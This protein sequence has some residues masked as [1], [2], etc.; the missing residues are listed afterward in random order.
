MTFSRQ[1]FAKNIYNLI[2]LLYVTLCSAY[3]TTITKFSPF[4]FGLFASFLLFF[5]SFFRISSIK[6]NKNK[7]VLLTFIILIALFSILNIFITNTYSYSFGIFFLL[8]LN[9]FSTLYI[10]STLK[11][12]NKIS[13]IR[14]SIHIYYWIA[15]IIGVCD[16]IYRYLTRL[17]SYHGLQYIYNF[18]MSSLMF[19]DA[20]WV[21]FIYMIAFSFFLY[22]YDIY[23]LV[24]K[25][26]L[27]VLF[28][29]VL[30]SISR[31]AFF[32]SIIVLIYSKFLKSPKKQKKLFLILLAIFSFVG[33][34]FVVDY[35]LHDDSFQTKLIILKGFS[36]YL[37][38][39]SIQ[40]LF[41]GFGFQFATS[42]RAE[43][44]MNYCGVIGHLYIVTKMMDFGMI[45]FA[46]EIIYFIVLLKLTQYR[47][48]YLLLPFLV[49]GLSMCPTNLSFFYTFAGI[50]LFL[51][52]RKRSFSYDRF[53]QRY[54][55]NLQCRTIC[56]RSNRINFKSILFK[57]RIRDC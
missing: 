24:R 9:Q 43:A 51:E 12:V 15:I 8:L 4:Y 34:P 38:H 13:V 54:N 19:T 17:H 50:M 21:G 37:T 6:R 26:Q 10:Y 47:F 3:I 22:L 48:F 53:N 5:L 35:V 18:K 11:R 39:T 44:A 7:K 27:Y 55:A 52:N 30:T 57:Y 32:S 36:Y 1:F 31:A 14:K 40:D 29:F 33:I 23:H 20:N 41:I 25:S 45:G 28:I 46:L 56:C 49:C 42:T 2:F 16:I